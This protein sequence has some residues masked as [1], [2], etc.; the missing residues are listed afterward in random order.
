MAPYVLGGKASSPATT[1][2][3]PVFR[4]LVAE[5][6]GRGTGACQQSEREWLLYRKPFLSASGRCRDPGTQRR[7]SHGSAQSSR[8][9]SRGDAGCWFR[10]AVQRPRHENT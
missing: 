5:S 4:L 9:G 2:Y 10:R 1:T 3:L 8:N 6:V 7:A